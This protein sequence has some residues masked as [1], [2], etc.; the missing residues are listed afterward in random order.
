MKKLLVGVLL[1]GALALGAMK[2]AALFTPRKVLIRDTRECPRV[3][4][5]TRDDVCPAGKPVLLI[6]AAD[7]SVTWSD[8]NP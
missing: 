5:Q 4:K 6:L 7:G 8:P 1:G 3:E 2:A